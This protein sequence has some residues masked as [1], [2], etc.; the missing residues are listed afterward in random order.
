M[1]LNNVVLATEDRLSEAV[2]TKIL[3]TLGFEIVNRPRQHRRSHQGGKSHLRKRAQEFN[4]S[5][6]GPDYFFM[7]T[8]LDSP[9]DCPANLIRS[10]VKGPLHPRFFLRVAVMEVESW[11]LADRRAIAAFLEISDGIPDKTDEILHPKEFLISLARKSR[12]RKLREDLVTEKRGIFKPGPRYNQRLI[13]FVQDFWD[14][15]RAAAV[16]PS[17]KRTVDKLHSAQPAQA[18]QSNVDVLS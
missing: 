7:L 14:L 6:A 3:T 15:E 9:Q 10:W 16:S 5:A 4:R 1:N 17:L 13:Q 11:V 2:A 8:D 18:T 12:V